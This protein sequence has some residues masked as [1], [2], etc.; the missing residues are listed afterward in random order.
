VGARSEARYVVYF[1][2]DPTHPR[3]VAIVDLDKAPRNAAGHVTF[4]ADLY[5]IAPKD[6]ARGNGAARWSGRRANCAGNSGGPSAPSGGP[7]SCFPQRSRG[8]ARM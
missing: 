1:S 7:E 4:S 3:N 5:V 2:I 8:A 6:V